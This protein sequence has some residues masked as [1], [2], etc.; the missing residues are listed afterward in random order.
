MD[1]SVWKSKQKWALILA[2]KCKGTL[3]GIYIRFVHNWEDLE[4]GF[5]ETK[6]ENNLGDSNF[7]KSC[8]SKKE[9]KST[10]R[11]GIIFIWHEKHH[12]VCKYA[13]YCASLAMKTMW[14]HAEQLSTCNIF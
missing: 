5:L 6:I 4:K 2:W 12:K 7:I 9:R 10:L 3:Y 1:N 11:I 14:V 13:T 8:T